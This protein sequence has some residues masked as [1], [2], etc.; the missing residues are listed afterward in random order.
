MTAGTSGCDAGNI[1]QIT[2]TAASYSQLAGL[3]AGFAFSAL[4]FLVSTRIKVPDP[5]DSFASAVVG[6]TISSFA[7]EV[8]SAV[9]LVGSEIASDVRP[10]QA[11]SLTTQD[12]IAPLL[13]CKALRCLGRTHNARV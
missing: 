11:T 12:R 4:I 8:T 13:E 9:Q 7:L 3:L 10:A 2:T 1:F 6:V 5:Q